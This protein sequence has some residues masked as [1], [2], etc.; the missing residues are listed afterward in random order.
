MQ[1]EKLNIRANRPDSAV[2]KLRPAR[3]HPYSQRMQI[4]QQIIN[5][6]LRQFLAVARH[7]VSAETD[8]VCGVL[9]VRRHSA[10]R[11]VFPMED[12]LQ[13]RA[14]PFARGVRLMA[15]VAVLVVDVPA[16][17]LLWVQT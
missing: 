4:G 8:N 17:G 9:I 3:P 11:Q 13:A 15:A 14:F 5:L 7:L 10:H 12:A 2:A 6:L 16:G 1:V